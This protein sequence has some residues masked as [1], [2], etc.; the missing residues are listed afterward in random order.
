LLRIRDRLG[1]GGSAEGWDGA[2]R[3]R[4]RRAEAVAD[5]GGG[6][7]S[8]GGAGRRGVRRPPESPA[9]GGQRIQ[10]PPPGAYARVCGRRREG[11]TPWSSQPPPHRTRSTSS[12]LSA[13]PSPASTAR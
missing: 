6:G 7:G 3:V 12:R 1:R 4:Q 8:A 11:V 10:D 2:R 9:G 5:R 13:S